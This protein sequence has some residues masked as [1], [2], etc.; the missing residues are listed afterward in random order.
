MDSTLLKIFVAVAQH[1]SISLGAQ[2][3]HFTQSN[4]T[5][6]IKQ[7]EKNLGYAL[8]HRV[9]KGVIL[10]YEGEKLYPYALEIVAKVEEA[11]RQMKN[12]THQ[13]LLRIGTSQANAIIRLLPFLEKLNADFPP[14]HIELYA[15]GT[16]PVIEALLDYKVDIAFVTGNPHHK[17][18]MVL[19]RFND[20]LYMVESKHK[21]SQNTIIGYREKSTHFQY[22]KSYCEAMGNSE[23]KTII[24]ENYEVMLGCAKAGMGR[25]FLSKIIVDKYGYTD[26]LNLIKLEQKECD[27]ET[28][29]ICRKDYVPIIGEYLKALNLD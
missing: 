22:F 23:Y 24:L 20:D 6:R 29:L 9:P 3:L 8:F 7:L 17:D 27:L 10:T 12:M 19:N 16:P 26:D 28:H 15:N 25:A 13:K 14:M 18:I 5:L 2:E 1:K 11:I 4:V 21:Q